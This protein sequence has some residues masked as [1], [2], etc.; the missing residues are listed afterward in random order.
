MVSQYVAPLAGQL[1]GFIRVAAQIQVRGR[2]LDPV[3]AS[4]IKQ[5][6]KSSQLTIKDL[7]QDED[8]KV[9]GKGVELSAR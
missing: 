3:S 1:I 4:S 7:V 8:L 5:L 6:M 2:R 9:K